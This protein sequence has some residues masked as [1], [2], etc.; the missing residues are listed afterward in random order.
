MTDADKMVRVAEVLALV[1]NCECRLEGMKIENRERERQGSAPAYGEECFATLPTACGC[2]INQMI[3][4][5]H[6]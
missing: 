3:Q 2:D 6:G 4:M 5:L 1:V